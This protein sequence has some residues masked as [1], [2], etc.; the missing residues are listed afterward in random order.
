MKKVTNPKEYTTDYHSEQGGNHKVETIVVQTTDINDQVVDDRVEIKSGETVVLMDRAA[1]NI[2]R[3]YPW[4]I[5]EDYVPEE[6]KKDVKSTKKS[7]RKSVK[8]R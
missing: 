5:V 1:E 7:K 6:V 3:K 4:L 8:K 2:K